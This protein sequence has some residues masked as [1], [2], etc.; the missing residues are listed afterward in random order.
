LSPRYLRSPCPSYQHC[1]STE[2]TVHS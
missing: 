2:I 1:T